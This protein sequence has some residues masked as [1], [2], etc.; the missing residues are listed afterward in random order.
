LCELA[1]ARA[2]LRNKG[3][4]TLA[5]GFNRFLAL[6]RG[7]GLSETKLPV[8]GF[9]LAGGKSLRM[10]QDK[11]LL[12]FC[13][14]PMIALALSKLQAFCTDVSI[15]GNRDDLQA[16]APVMREELLNAGPAAGIVAGLRGASQPWVMFLPVDVPLVPAQLLQNWATAVLE[17]GLAG[18]GASYLLVNGQ[19]QPAFCMLRRECYPSVTRAIEGGERRLDEILMSVDDDEGAGSLWVC[20]ASRF[21]GKPDVPSLDL[22]FWFS[23][24]NT[25]RELAEAELW[26]Q[27]RTA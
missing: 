12:P 20:D 10:G 18:C 19:R 1:K 26:A 23:N 24:V 17:E 25:P 16:F 22:E 3:K 13:G 4:T 14:R 21:A 7:E 2:Y 6:A 9:V 8:H 11:A 5:K 27:H 15:V